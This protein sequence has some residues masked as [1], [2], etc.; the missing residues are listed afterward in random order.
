MPHP[1]GHL[2]KK[3]SEMYEKQHSVKRQNVLKDKVEAL[4][5]TLTPK[6]DSRGLPYSSEYFDACLN[7]VEEGEKMLIEANRQLKKFSPDNHDIY[8]CQDELLNYVF[9]A[10]EE[11]KKLK[12]DL[13]NVVKKVGELK[14]L[15][16]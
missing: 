5:K 1:I 11:T 6:S 9:D 10:I 8:V 2:K 15:C 16:L 3:L 4:K 7:L 14:K 13:R 12:S